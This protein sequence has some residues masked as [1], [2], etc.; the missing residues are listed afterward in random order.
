MDPLTTPSGPARAVGV[1]VCGTMLVA[2]LALVVSLA[3][4]QSSAP[5]GVGV[6][7][8]AAPPVAVTVPPAPA[9]RVTTPT[10]PAYAVSA[11]W[12]TRTAIASGISE[13]AIRAYATA[14]LRMA[15]RDPSCGLGW[16][17][18][19]GIGWVESQ[20]GTIG[21]RLLGADGRADRPISGPALDGAGDLAAIRAA[22]GR[23]E[24]AVGPL[25]F[26]PSTWA[27]W[28][29]DGDGDGRKDPQDLDDAAWAAA[30]YLCASGLDLRT[31][32]GW[33]GAIRSYNHSDAYV[34][35][36]YDAASAYA[37]RTR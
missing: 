23:W 29:A 19:A 16:T 18:L 22:S 12:V 28:G 2:V 3:R 1:A 6:E 25:Q 9:A 33:A 11:A 5:A 20:Q 4:T 24:R 30:R 26:L 27:T 13:T 21:G 10:S 7:L 17:T 32:A 37:A 34:Q 31:G 8:V 35:A 15:R 36:V 14:T